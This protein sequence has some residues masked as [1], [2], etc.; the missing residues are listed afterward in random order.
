MQPLTTVFD[1]LI[2]AFENDSNSDG[3]GVG[4]QVN[5]VERFDGEAAVAIQEHKLRRSGE[6][7]SVLVGFNTETGALRSA[8]GRPIKT[9]LPVAVLVVVPSRPKQRSEAARRLDKLQDAVEEVV[10]ELRPNDVGV[11][12]LAWRSSRGLPGGKEWSG[13]AVMVDLQRN[14]RM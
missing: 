11:A 7:A 10:R 3:T 4:D 13:R 2:S 5:T 14:R 9:D 8:A 6:G 12:A 1:N